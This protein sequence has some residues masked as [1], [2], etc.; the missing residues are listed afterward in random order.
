MIIRPRKEFQNGVPERSLLESCLKEHTEGVGRLARLRA[1]YDGRHAIE[2]RVRSAGLPNLRIAHAF[3]RYISTMAAGYLIGNPVQYESEGQEDAL[4]AVKREYAG[5]A[6]DSVDAELARDASIYGKGVE[7][8]FADGSACPRTAALD[9]RDAFVV[10]DDSVENKPMLGMYSAPWRAP[11]GRLLG[12]I[13]HVYTER[14][15]LVYRVKSLADPK[16]L[17][18]ES[19]QPHYFGQVPLIEY[20]NDEDE[21]GDFEGVIPLIDAYNLLQSDRMNDKQQ[22]VDALLVLYGC[23][24]ETDSRGRTPGQQ[25]REDKALS[26]PD[27]DAH[28]EWLC[29]QLNEADTEV[30]RDAIKSDIHKMSMV[31]DLTDAQFAGNSSGVAMRYKLL[32]L[33]QL[34]KI[35]E[36]WFRE[37]LRSRL[38]AYAHFLACRGEA[39][40]DAERVRMIFTRAL[41][42]NELE[43]AQTLEALKDVLPKEELERRAMRLSGMV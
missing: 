41:P 31:P 32:G 22:F 8:L 5:G 21:K 13:V 1:Y 19:I 11:D 14:D 29:K 20:W 39:W 43:Q 26:L 37:A 4:A 34:T 25:L 16:M 27:C 38:R 17:E 15:A 24:L 7:L 36:R 30:L 42:A 6:V 28:A 12:F 23:T 35:K 9:P 18:P 2:H 3:P 10:Y 40:L 33:E